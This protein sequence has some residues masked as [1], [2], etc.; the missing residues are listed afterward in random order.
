MKRSVNLRRKSFSP[1][2]QDLLATFRR[3]GMSDEEI[4]A[5]LLKMKSKAIVGVEVDGKIVETFD[6]G[7]P[8]VETG[9]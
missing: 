1:S 7:K 6:D 9:G 2:A 5:E 8:P 4:K 3:L